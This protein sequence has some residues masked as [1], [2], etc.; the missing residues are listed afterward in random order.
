MNLPL[1]LF[2]FFLLIFPRLLQFQEATALAA[3]RSS[4]MV[5]GDVI[6]SPSKPKPED[7]SNKL[8]QLAADFDRAYFGAGE[9]GSAKMY[10][11]STF[12][13]TAYRRL[14]AELMK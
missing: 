1:F 2:S 13:M 10:L 7:A 14:G 12:Y 11:P 5:P 3:T 9:K 8:V 6:A 4:E